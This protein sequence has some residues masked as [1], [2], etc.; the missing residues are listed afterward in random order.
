M[1]IVVEIL[2]GL[3]TL[4][5]GFQIGSIVEYIKKYNFADLELD[6]IHALEARI[7]ALEEAAVADVKKVL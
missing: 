3:V 4:F 5:T 1:R 6:T 7:K 2:G